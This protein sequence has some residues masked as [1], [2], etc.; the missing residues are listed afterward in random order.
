MMYIFII[1]SS[2][3]AGYRHADLALVRTKFVVAG[4]LSDILQFLCPP[5][6][7]LCVKSTP[8]SPAADE[9]LQ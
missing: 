4:L 7:R 1:D 2:L 8:L 9:Q 6:L 3:S 5:D